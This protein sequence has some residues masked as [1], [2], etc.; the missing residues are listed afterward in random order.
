MQFA[1]EYVEGMYN[2]PGI[3]V[4]VLVCVHACVCVCVAV[5]V[6]IV[7]FVVYFVLQRAQWKCNQRAAI[8]SDYQECA[9]KH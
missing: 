7:L 2:A 8:P 9:E 5:L 3:H 6:C 4:T 1:V